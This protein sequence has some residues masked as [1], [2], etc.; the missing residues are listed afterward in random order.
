RDGARKEEISNRL[1]RR[2]RRRLSSDFDAETGRQTVAAFEEENAR[3][4]K[5]E[6]TASAS[7]FAFWDNFGL[8]L[9]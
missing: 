1:R 8:T 6:E 3:N 4:A 7:S 9:N 5:K 2:K